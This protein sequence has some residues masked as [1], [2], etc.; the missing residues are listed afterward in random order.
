MDFASPPAEPPAS[1][2]RSGELLGY[3]AD[4][5]VV[6]INLDDFGMYHAI[7]AAVIASIEAGIASSCSLMVPCPGAQDAMRLLRGKPEIPFGIHLTLVCDTTHDRWGPLTGKEKVPSLLDAAGELY[8]PAQR[9]EL[10]ARARL[11]EVELEFRAQIDAVIDAGLAPT[12]LDWHCLADGG[13]DD[14]FDLSVGLAEEH[15]LAVRAWLDPARR[16]LRHRGLPVV[17]HDFLDSFSLDLD[18]KAARYAQLLRDLPAGLSE[19]AVHPGLG[20][21]EAQA[22]DPDGWRVRQTD[23]EFLTSPEARDILQQ[24]GIVVTDHRSIQQAWLA[25]LT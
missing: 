21:E 13:R 2:A 11:D 25:R 1:P 12:H 9:P 5:R 8:P 16:K 10:L 24:E 15:G 6:I 14:I 22:V 18:G 20:T 4:A 19:W 17:D 7:N 23:Y 3:P